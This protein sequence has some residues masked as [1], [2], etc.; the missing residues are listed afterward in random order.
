MYQEPLSTSGGQTRAS[1]PLELE[2]EKVGCWQLN[3]DPLREGLSGLKRQ[4]TSQASQSFSLS[5]AM[6]GVLK[7]GFKSDIISAPPLFDA[8]ISPLEHPFPPF[9]LY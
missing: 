2:L 7:I 3:L 6:P 8:Y 1:D 9:C 4:T 5:L